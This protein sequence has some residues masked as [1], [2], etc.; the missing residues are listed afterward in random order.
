LPPGVARALDRLSLQ[1]SADSPIE[2]LEGA[3]WGLFEWRDYPAPW[4]RPP[5]IGEGEEQLVER[6]ESLARHAAKGPSG[7]DDLLTSLAPV[8]EAAA[9]IGRSKRERV[10]PAGQIE[11]Q[12]AAVR[13]GL[14]PPGRYRKKGRG[15]SFGSVP[16][17]LVIAEREQLAEA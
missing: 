12:L 11:A 4:A 17:S 8:C 15:A 5:A 13:R 10:V 2:R 16:R 7:R 1:A 9:W 6:I 14:G 3:A